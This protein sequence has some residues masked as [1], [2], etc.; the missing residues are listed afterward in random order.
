[1]TCMLSD[2]AVCC[3]I[4]VQ[5]GVSIMT[6][7]TYNGR[8]ENGNALW[9]SCANIRVRNYEKAASCQELIQSFNINTNRWMAK[10]V[11]SAASVHS[12]CWA[13]DV[14]SLAANLLKVPEFYKFN[15]VV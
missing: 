14:L 9:D 6:G 12:V 5:E 4:V 10:W 1:M 3:F 11:V 2:W 13:E 7:L 8:D 15:V